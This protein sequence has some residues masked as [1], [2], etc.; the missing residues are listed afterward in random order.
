[1]APSH[2][3]LT[4][5]IFGVS[6]LIAGIVSLLYPFD[7][8]AEN[9]K[10]AAAGN[11]LAA[12]AMGLYY[13]IAAYQENTVFFMATVPMRSLTTVVFWHYNWKGAAAWEGVGA[14]LT[15][16]ALLIRGKQGDSEGKKK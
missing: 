16:I 10:P 1:M 7:E 2:A 11:A 3:A 12:I 9:C 8:G 14:A 6:A 13:S 5:Y 4:I 15:L